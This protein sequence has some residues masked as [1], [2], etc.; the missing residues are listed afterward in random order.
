MASICD[1]DKNIRSWLK[2]LFVPKVLCLN[3]ARVG[4]HCKK[5]GLS[6]TQ[7]M[8]PFAVMENHGVPIRTPSGHSSTMTGFRVKL[9]PSSYYSPLPLHELDQELSTIV[10]ST[11]PATP[12]VDRLIKQQIITGR[13][14]PKF[15]NT[16]CTAEDPQKGDGTPWYTAARSAFACAQRFQS[17]ERLDQPLSI[18]L[19]ISTLEPDPIAAL[20]ELQLGPGYPKQLKNGNFSAHVPKFIF[21]IH[22]TCLAH[23]VDPQKV[24][25][26][27]HGYFRPDQCKL[28]TVNS[29][30]DASPNMG[31]PD[32]W[33]KEMSWSEARMAQ[34]L[35]AGQVG[36]R[37]GKC[38]PFGA[39]LSPEDLMGLQGVMNEVVTKGV[40]PE[41]E[42]R[43]F[44]LNQ[45][46]SQNRKGVKN[47]LKSW[48][49]RKPKESPKREGP[50]N[51]ANGSGPLYD[52][53]TIESQ[54]RLLADLAFMVRDYELALSMYRMVRDDFK[55]DKAWHHFASASDMIGLTT[56]LS[57]GSHRDMMSAFE[58]AIAY[59][60]KP[61]GVDEIEDRWVRV[62][63]ATRSTVLAS[64]LLRACGSPENFRI[65]STLLQNAARA[66]E[67][68]GNGHLVAA[69]LH[70][71]AALCSLTDPTP[72]IRIS[73]RQFL[74]AG[75][76]YAYSGRMA[77][78]FHAYAAV[79]SLYKNE[80]G[81]NRVTSHMN[82]WLGRQL[83]TLAENRLAAD[84]LVDLVNHRDIKKMPPRLQGVAL[85]DFFRIVAS[86]CA[87]TKP[88]RVKLPC[89]D[90]E[91]MLVLV[92]ENA[93]GAGFSYFERP[94]CYSFEPKP[95]IEAGRSWTDLD[96]EVERFEDGWKTLQKP[97]MPK[98]RKRLVETKEPSQWCAAG[99]T[100]KV[101]LSAWNPLAYPLKVLELRLNATLCVDSGDMGTEGLQI[102]RYPAFT[103]DAQKEKQLELAVLVQ[104]AGML[105]IEGLLWKLEGLTK[106]REKVLCI[107]DFA[108]K[109][110][111]LNNSRTSSSIGARLNDC[112]NLVK[113]VDKRPLLG[114]E[115][116][117]LR[118]EGLEGQVSSGTIRL[119]NLGQTAITFLRIFCSCPS[120]LV[121][122]EHL[123]GAHLDGA[124][125]EIPISL[126][127][128]EKKELP[129]FTCMPTLASGQERVRL[130]FLYAA[131]H[132]PSDRKFHL[133]RVR[134]QIDLSI[135]PCVTLQGFLRPH[136]L[137]IRGVILVVRIQNGVTCVKDGV[138]NSTP[139]VNIEHL[140]VLAPGW[141]VSEGPVAN[142]SCTLGAGE[143]FTTMF[144]LK[145]CDKKV[146]GGMDFE[147]FSFISN[148]ARKTIHLDLKKVPEGKLFLLQHCQKFIS[149]LGSNSAQGDEEETQSKD[150]PRTIQ[151]IR[152]AANRRKESMNTLVGEATHDVPIPWSATAC[153]W[154]ID[155]G[156]SIVGTWAN[157]EIRVEGQAHMCRLPCRPTGSGVLDI[158]PFLLTCTYPKMV[159]H[160]FKNGPCAVDVQFHLCRK[161]ADMFAPQKYMF[162]ALQSKETV[163]GFFRWAGLTRSKVE[164]QAGETATFSLK[165]IML[166]FGLHNLNSVQVVSDNS[167]MIFPNLQFMCEVISV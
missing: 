63:L 8:A 132:E 9:L 70:E 87:N 104:R 147:A 80:P 1:R 105:K 120:F 127:P 32:M 59:H 47:M 144:Y 18:I 125:Y 112:R 165:A 55:S 11:A 114:V 23:A 122:S 123:R 89:F 36:E 101:V 90:D 115:M 91:K 49:G 145:P 68:G 88:C 134:T 141:H 153:A 85:A 124:L 136:P 126:K 57:N 155:P 69:L 31:Q 162:E 103:I 67:N 33:T 60:V 78:S 119:S 76:H 161:N 30:P 158:C 117:G 93:A 143:S 77:H 84:S 113:V 99:E 86:G 133:R 56:Y 15:L 111:P 164:L 58:A 12:P 118:S 94:A 166:K 74:T 92:L 25:R 135:S 66:E 121:L 19:A 53:N 65:A 82:H 22:D 167:V 83:S 52:V 40:A 35:A 3:S 95:L 44:S 160:N 38:L 142:D 98:L 102:E 108:F 34:E 100:V 42:R 106:G 157:K 151:E 5:N 24:V 48:W 45:E 156:I 2:T 50:G 62:R 109:G 116:D 146:Q 13:D 75:Y 39:L 28:V 107:H 26:I 148:S 71:Q 7:L 64:E 20:K 14:I 46:I 73:A 149:S 43:M 6:F 130:L 37:T 139:T 16:I 140:H 4:E 79:S 96:E 152:E 54:I 110:M 159:E 29:F 21:I 51:T 97:K 131:E 129:M 61:G 72:R 81:W 163:L 154:G 41:I 128:G 27:L 137:E 138:T 150:R 17:H 10:R